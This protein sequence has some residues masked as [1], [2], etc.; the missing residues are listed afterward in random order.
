MDETYSVVVGDVA[1]E[2]A[3]FD[4]PGEGMLESS[5]EDFNVRLE[6]GVGT[7]MEAERT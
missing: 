2:S 1:I 3:K 6:V 7:A 4:F 5:N